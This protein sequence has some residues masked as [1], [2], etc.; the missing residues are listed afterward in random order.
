ML[1][2]Y[3]FFTPPSS[4]LW[5]QSAPPPRAGTP[6]KT[7]H[8]SILLWQS[9]NGSASAGPCACVRIRAFVVL[10]SLEGRD[11]IAGRETAGAPAIRSP[12]DERPRAQERVLQPGRSAPGAPR[13]RPCSAERRMIASCCGFCV[14]ALAGLEMRTP[15]GSWSLVTEC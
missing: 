10:Q 6:Q 15:E 12:P 4:Q 1:C 5:W 2:P 13:A 8:V 14:H 3:P 11:G 9:R 7:T